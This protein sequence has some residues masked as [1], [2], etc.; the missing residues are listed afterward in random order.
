MMKLFR[1]S[2]CRSLDAKARLMLP[3]EYREAIIASSEDNEAG[4]FV[5]TGF[6]GRLVGYTLKDWEDNAAQLEQIKMPSVNLSRFISKV[7]GLAEEITPDP[8]GRIRIPR[9]LLREAKLCKDVQLVGIGRR[10]EIW[11]QTT[12]DELQ[13]A[14][15]S[16]ELTAAGVNISM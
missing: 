15:V 11:D 14:D 12:F 5:L 9:P 6:Q 3:P 1:R 7:L 16:E 8:Q 13:F 2:H 10:F 4:T